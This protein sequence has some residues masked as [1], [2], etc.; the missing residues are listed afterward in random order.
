MHP[1]F[2]RDSKLF[3]GFW[4][5][6]WRDVV[7]Y[8]H[9]YEM[10]HMAHVRNKKTKNLLKLDQQAKVSVVKYGK[11]RKIP[12]YH[13]VL[14]SFF[15]HI[16][17]NN[18]VCDHIDENRLN[19]CVNNLQWL[20]RSANSTKSLNLRPR[21]HAPA[22]SKPVEQWSKDRATFIAK[23]NS[24]REAARITHISQGGISNCAVGRNHSAGGFFWKF[25]EVESQY[26]LPGEQ[27]ATNDTLRNM[28]SNPK[29]RVSNMG[30]ILT[31]QGIKTKGKIVKGTS[32]HREYEGQTVHKL[33]WVVW[34]DGRP[35][36]KKGDTLVICHN[37]AIPRDKD[38]C[39]S[40]AIE[41][42]RLD[43]QSE[44]MKEHYRTKA[45]KRTYTLMS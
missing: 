10:N 20:S 27:W 8:E 33:V 2:D 29:I 38:G 3:Y 35:L 21:N 1:I 28:F 9:L 22:T 24:A 37:D 4:T 31:A 13:L 40:N 41:H 25:E 42:L 16:P 23:Y 11:A 18:R 36:P 17:R 5:K 34:G 43:T 15:P 7:G 14:I 26:D 19:N 32:G 12:V 30:R 45:Q 6:G 44:N 39:V